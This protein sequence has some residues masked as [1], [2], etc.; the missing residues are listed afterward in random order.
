MSVLQKYPRPVNIIALINFIAFALLYIYQ[1]PLDNY[2][3]L[4]GLL[5]IGIIYLSDMLMTKL[6]YEDEILFLI[7][8]MLSS[9]GIIIIYRLDPDLGVKQVIWFMTGVTLFFCTA[10]LYGKFKFWDRIIYLYPLVSIVLFILTLLLGI[11]VKGSTNWIQIGRFSFQ[12]SEIIKLLFVFFMAAYYRHPEKLAISNFKLKEWDITIDHKYVFV[13]LVYL[14]MGFLVIQKELG[15]LLLF[16]LIYVIFLYVFDCN[17]KFLLTNI[18]IAFFGALTSVAFLHHV[19][20]RVEA[21][22]NPWADIAGKGYQITQS[23]FAIGSGGFFGTGIGLGQP[24]YIPEVHTDFIF[25]AICEEMGV[26]GGIAVILLYLIL[27]YRGIKITLSAKKLFY[28]AVALGITAMFGFQSFIIIGGVIR[29][30]PL[31]GIT[32][33]FISYGGSSLT[34]SFVALGILQAIS[35]KSFGEEEAC[36]SEPEGEAEGEQENN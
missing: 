16:F 23:L 5:I 3:I 2:I 15:T 30:I 22:L 32:L 27:L 14:H 26:F 12:P 9:V 10:G 18:G 1:K 20:V 25:S 11:K 35:L 34:T 13:F 24:E 8:S 28:R 17:L 29:L 19:Q 4:A 36:E 21:W 7:V 31:T 33:P 6:N